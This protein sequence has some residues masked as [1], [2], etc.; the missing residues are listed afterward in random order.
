MYA[1]RL[2]RCYLEGCY[3]EDSTFEVITDNQVLKHFFTKPTLSR[4]EARW[5]DFLS[6]FGISAVALKPRRIHVLGDELSRIPPDL[7]TME[8]NNIQLLDVHSPRVFESNHEVDQTFGPILRALKGNWPSDRV[9]RDRVSRLLPLFQLE[10]NRL[11]YD[12]R[13]CV[14]QPP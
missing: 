3:L 5:L 6:Q 13:L 11:L 4:R 2:F 8:I 7:S 10:G 9:Q 14:V 1:L 12:G